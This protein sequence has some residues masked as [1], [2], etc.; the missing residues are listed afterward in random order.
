MRLLLQS[1]ARECVCT[2]ECEFAPKERIRGGV[3]SFSGEPPLL[4]S[5]GGDEV[6]VVHGLSAMQLAMPRVHKRST[7]K[8]PSKRPQLAK[9]CVTCHGPCGGAHQHSLG[10]PNFQTTLWPIIH[11]C[12]AAHARGARGVRRG[13]WDVCGATGAGPGGPQGAHLGAPWSES[14]RSCPLAGKL[15]KIEPLLGS[16]LYVFFGFF[17][18]VIVISVVMLISQI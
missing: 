3:A 13:H 17:W 8:R 12:F 18:N 16:T 9:S 1:G 10:E 6:D 11:S 15:S 2:H 4:L 14:G 7:S 5:D